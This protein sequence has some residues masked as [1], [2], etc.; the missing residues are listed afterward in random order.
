MLIGVRKRRFQLPSLVRLK[1]VLVK[2]TKA[3]TRVEQVIDSEPA[4]AK[5][6]RHGLDPRA[7]MMGQGEPPAQANNV[8]EV[9][10][11]TQVK[12]TASNADLESEGESD[13]SASALRRL[14]LVEDHPLFRGAFESLL[15][16]FAPNA[17]ILSAGTLGGVTQFI[18]SGEQIDC[19]FVDLELPDAQGFE[20][21]HKLHG[22]LP[23]M[24]II[25][26]SALGNGLTRES[27]LSEGAFEVLSKVSN[28]EEYFRTLPLILDTVAKLPRSEAQDRTSL[29]ERRFGLSP[30]QAQIAEYLIE[31]KRNGA[32][33]LELG[34]SGHTVKVHITKLFYT[35]GAKSRAEATAILLSDEVITR[36][37]TGVNKSD[38]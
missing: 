24:P 16:A 34:I 6:P 4:S 25:V 35:L 31:G 3:Y 21:I 17:A 10:G 2:E 36:P 27:C 29:L 1:S 7:L 12:P 32:I 19:A 22:V 18:N 8:N 13:R 5:L 26:V 33:A 14:L 23:D 28:Q 37:S 30:R 38:E 20:G 9:A 15:R 11:S